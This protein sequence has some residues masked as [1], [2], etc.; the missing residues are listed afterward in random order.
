MSEHQCHVAVSSKDFS[1][2]HA[3]EIL[4]VC[5]QDTSDDDKAEQS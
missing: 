5:D 2:S 4:N 1:K 3:W